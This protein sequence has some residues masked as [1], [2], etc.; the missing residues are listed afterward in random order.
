MLVDVSPDEIAMGM[1]VHGFKG[2][3]LHHPF[4]R[5]KFLVDDDRVLER[6]R[7]STVDAVII[8]IE[9]GAGAASPATSPHVATV[10]VESIARPSRPYRRPD[11]QP[12]YQRDPDS[13]EVERAR[14]IIARGK[15]LV[16]RLFDDARLGTLSM[17]NEIVGLVEEISASL[18]RSRTTLI[19]I[20]RLKTKDEYTYLHSVAVCALMMNFGRQLGMDE[21][22][23]R[24]LGI[25]G[26][27]HDVGKMAVPIDLLN[28]AGKL[29]DE[30]FAQMKRHTAAG[31]DLLKACDKVPSVALDVALHHHERMDGTGYPDGLRGNAFSLAARM[32]AICDIYDAL[33]SDRIYKEAWTPADAISRMR[34]WTDHLDQDLLFSFMQSITVYPPGMLV[35]LRS[36]RLGIILPNGRRASRPRARAF[37]AIADG[38]FIAAQDV[39][40]SD[41][42]NTDQAMA[43]AVP[44]H[45]PIGDWTSLQ[46]HLLAGS[47]V[48]P[49]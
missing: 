44:A 24:D 19:S 45:W 14:T 10:Q 15:R 34:G 35:R 8:D 25:A 40:L 27:F 41:S 32:G 11:R 48:P 31:H 29:S 26:L 23:I 6:I 28:K 7:S 47:Y 3:W 21:A 37:Y 20:A 5:A 1:Y 39:A 43:A 33:T 46:A 4:W 38:T 30:E 18:E 42:L 16:L 9:K 49:G 2:S 13:I 22:E 36:N 17:S 12:P